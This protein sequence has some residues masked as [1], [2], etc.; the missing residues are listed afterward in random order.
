M[1]KEYSSSQQNEWSLT[2][3]THI[4]SIILIRQK[5]ETIATVHDLLPYSSKSPS[6]RLLSILES[7]YLD[8]KYIFSFHAAMSFAD[9]P[10][11]S[12]NVYEE[13]KMGH[14][15]AYERSPYA[16]KY[17]FWHVAIEYSQN[18]CQSLIPNLHRPRDRSIQSHENTDYQN[19]QATNIFS[20]QTLH[21]AIIQ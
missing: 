6:S 9:V 21:L 10:V 11:A 1:R 16:T 17:E 13:R 7:N 4:F 19:L 18:Q 2:A 20:S 3:E 5:I 12:S 14:G 8:L 15:T